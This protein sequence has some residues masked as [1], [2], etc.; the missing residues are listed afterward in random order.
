MIISA[1]RRTDIPAFYARWFINR[2]RAGYCTVP[3]PFNAHQVSRV[4]LSPGAVDAIVFWTRNP[5]PLF[6]YLDELHKGG[7]RFYFQYTLMDNP[8]YLD[9]R[10]VGLEASLHTFREL[11]KRTDPKRVVLRY[12]PIVFSNQTD[13]AFHKVTFQYIADALCGYTKR[14]VISIMDKYAR[15][16][17]RLQALAQ[18]GIC[19]VPDQQIAQQIVLL[20]PW[21]VRSAEINHMEI[22]SCAEECDLSPFGVHTGSCIDSRLIQQLFEVNLSAGKDTNQRKGCGCTI[23]KDIGSY[24][25]CL[26]QC[27]YCY[28]TTS[29]PLAQTRHAR[30]DPDGE[31]LI[32]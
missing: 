2:I 20:V 7:Y 30:H 6:P 32:P 29:F 18:M 23:S 28:A 3:N 1:S 10:M 15:I 8:S 11:V 25:S 17:P 12:D 9:P 4:D 27:T 16:T 22:F 24:D 5:R 14:V 26:F 13:T 19:L 21:M 31:K